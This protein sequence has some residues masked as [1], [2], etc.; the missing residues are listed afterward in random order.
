MENTLW[1]SAKDNTFLWISRIRGDIVHCTDYTVNGSQDW[2]KIYYRVNAYLIA[3]EFKQVFVGTKINDEN[4]IT[5]VVTDLHPI[6]I[7]HTN[8]TSS[9]C[10]PYSDV[11]HWIKSRHCVVHFNYVDATEILNN[12]GR[13]KCF[14]CRCPTEQRR[15]FS[16]MSVREMCPRC[17][18]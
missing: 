2:T 4:G 17:K 18:V 8:E 16:D 5:Y 6:G 3:C 11:L 12:K 10:Y 14:I 7:R 15:D 13:A 1:Y 9:N